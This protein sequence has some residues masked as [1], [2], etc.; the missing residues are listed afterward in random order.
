MWKK[1]SSGIFLS[2]QFTKAKLEYEKIKN[3]HYI[4]FNSPI[5]LSQQEQ[6]FE[7][8]HMMMRKHD[9]LLGCITFW[10]VEHKVVPGFFHFKYLPAN[11]IENE[12]QNHL[13][14]RLSSFFHGNSI[15]EQLA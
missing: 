3:I 13:I 14:K 12:N 1:C 4:H 7:T 9:N 10:S 5:K 11:N 15:F 2:E 6:K 8:T